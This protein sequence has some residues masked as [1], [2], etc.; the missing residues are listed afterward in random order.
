[1]ADMQVA[2]RLTLENLASGPLG[3]FA[4]QLKAMEPAVQALNARLSVFGRR[5]VSVGTSAENSAAG[6]GKLEAALAALGERLAGL[7]AKLSASMDGF[8]TLGAAARDAGASALAAGAGI[9]AATDAMNAAAASAGR[10]KAEMSGMSTVMKDMIGLFAAFEAYKGIK[11]S[12][13]S[14]ADLASLQAQMRLRGATQSNI[15]TATQQSWQNSKAFPLVSAYDAL[16]ARQ[17]L[18]VATGTKDPNAFNAALPQILANAVAYKAA[19]NKKASLADIIGNFGGIAEIRGLSQTS[20]GLIQ[21][22]ND[23]LRVAEATGGR[24][25]IGSQEVALRQYKYGGAMLESPTGYYRMMA[26]AEQQTL[27]GH[28]GGSGGG[29]GVSM[30][31]TAYGML[32]KVMNGGTMA[33]QTADMLQAMG[34][35]TSAVKKV[36][37]TTTSTYTSAALQGSITGQRDPAGWARNVLLPHM[38]ALALANKSQYFP[39]GNINN[40]RA[41]E[42]ALNRI[43]IQTWGKTGGVNVANLV[44]QVSNPHVWDRI[45]NTMKLAQNVP[46]GQAAVKNLSPYD[47]ATTALTVAI[48]N[49]KT[50]IGT[51]LLPQIKKL[52]TG[53]SKVVN[54]FTNLADR[55]P[56]LTKYFADLVGVLGALLAVEIVAKFVGLGQSIARMTGVFESGA[57]TIFRS[58]SGFVADLSEGAAHAGM[59]LGAL[60]TAVAG[61]VAALTVIGGTLYTF[62]GVLFDNTL[63]KND[64][65]NGKGQGSVAF[66][67]SIKAR[68]AEDAANGKTPW[69]APIPAGHHWDAKAGIV[70]ANPGTPVNPFSAPSS[71]HAQSLASVFGAHAKAAHFKLTPQQLA[72]AWGLQDAHRAG[73]EA[74]QSM[75]ALTSPIAK[76]RSAMATYG[77]KTDPAHVWYQRASQLASSSN[78]ADQ[79]LAVHA[80]QIGDAV[81]QKEALKAAKSHLATLQGQLAANIKL[82]AAKVTGGVLTAD[83]AQSRTLADQRAA[84]PGLLAAVRAVQALTPAGTAAATA[85][86]ALNVKMQQYGQGLTQFQQKI[87]NGVQ[88]AFSGLFNGL[89]QGKLTFR[90]EMAKF[91]QSCPRRSQFDPPCRSQLD[92]GMGAG[93]VAA[94]CG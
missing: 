21:A 85:L 28:E 87:Y 76:A 8:T 73:V 26:L 37:T 75:S 40:P 14:G 70:V 90:Q 79:A 16:H 61:A 35:F 60:A 15:N 89:M 9:G 92:P 17:A 93:V 56:T 83:Q 1:M 78:P 66:L 41:Q 18:M 74:K 39:Q 12:V 91:V 65:A 31:G 59:S 68:L 3:T 51:D 64:S 29:R 36:A 38:I 34:M 47:K 57:K 22:S 7:E 67:P 48:K 55:F 94:G 86:Q 71:I 50:A 2:M 44:S 49:L 54:W 72:N 63:G 45:N 19:F 6:T 46:V 30:T 4:D 42:E 43:A 13:H 88:N 62:W 82:N 52:A 80:Q 10:A 33:K 77:N 5:I 81:A 25:K 53:I 20:A 84:A 58:I 32:L 27:A 11:A 24:M 69:G 23:A